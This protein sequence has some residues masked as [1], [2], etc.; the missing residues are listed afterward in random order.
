MGSLDA[1]RAFL[2][3]PNFALGGALP[4]E[5]L[6]TAEGEQLVLSELQTQAAGGPV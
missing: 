3:T 1:A 6:K 2:R 5:L 4:R